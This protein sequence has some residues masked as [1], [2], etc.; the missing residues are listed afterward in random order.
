MGVLGWGYKDLGQFEKALEYYDKAIRLSPHDP[1]LFNFH[2]GKSEAYFALKQYDQAIDSARKSIAI[3]PDFDFAH[4][5]LIAGLVSAG[6]EAEAKEALQ[7]YLALPNAGFRTIAAWDA[8]KAQ[9]TGPQSDPRVLE[10]WDRLVEGLRKAGM[11]E[12]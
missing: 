8:Y 3:R 11:P 12:T 7:R 9:N 5:D 10:S 4:R 1:S 6:R 2:E